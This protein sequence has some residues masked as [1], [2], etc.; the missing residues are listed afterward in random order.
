MPKH[1]QSGA[2]QCKRCLRWFLSQGGLTE[3][4]CAPDFAAPPSVPMTSSSQKPSHTCCAAH[5]GSC[6]RC[7]RSM[8]GF[9]QH[10]CERD[11]RVS[12]ETRALYEDVCDKCGRRF[13][14]SQDLKR[15]IPSLC[16]GFRPSPF[17]TLAPFG[18]GVLS[19]DSQSILVVVVVAA[20]AAAVLV[21]VVRA[22]FPDTSLV[23]ADHR[24]IPAPAQNHQQIAVCA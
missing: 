1:L 21:V 22:C 6:G 14:C 17:L 12:A 7:F 4:K 20:A 2:A 18:S 3:H 24:P 11:K 16:Q 15:H 13:R 19:Y 8:S 5:C 23:C 10:N 9:P